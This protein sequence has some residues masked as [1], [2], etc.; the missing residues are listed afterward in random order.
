VPGFSLPRV[1]VRL[2]GFGSA[3][4]EPFIYP[5]EPVPRTAVLVP[6]FRGGVSPGQVPGFISGGVSG[7]PR[8]APE[9]GG[10]S[11]QPRQIKGK[12]LKLSEPLRSGEIFGAEHI[13]IFPGGWSDEVAS[14]E[15][16]AVAGTLDQLRALVGLPI[17]SLTHALIVLLRPDRASNW[18]Q[19]ALTQSERDW[20]WRVFGLPVF[21]QV[22]GKRGRLLATECEAHNGM[23]VRTKRCYSATKT[24]SGELMICRSEE[25]GSSRIERTTKL[26]VA[27][28]PCGRE[29]PR[30]HTVSSAT[31]SS[32][33]VSSATVSSAVVSPAAA[34]VASTAASAAARIVSGEPGPIA[35]VPGATGSDVSWPAMGIDIGT[36]MESSLAAKPAVTHLE[37]IK[38]GTVTAAVANTIADTEIKAST[39]KIPRV[40]AAHG[41]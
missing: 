3:P 6:W 33:T 38:T 32:A 25:I 36:E 14:F 30:I 17:P 7:N 11:R 35:N 24:G 9:G 34:I 12:A 40:R 8:S 18:A 39:F 29:T 4:L 13:R 21:E 22:I 20:F 28:C 2:T 26:V 10:P 23:H 41:G 19:Y 31:V 27:L 16:S 1:R 5:V 37:A 15:P